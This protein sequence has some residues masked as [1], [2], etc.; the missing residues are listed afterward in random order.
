MIDFKD[1]DPLKE[2]TKEQID[3]IRFP[4]YEELLEAIKIGEEMQRE[5]L[6]LWPTLP[7]FYRL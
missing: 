1:V 6:R 7:G 3:N 2:L 5:A 4:T